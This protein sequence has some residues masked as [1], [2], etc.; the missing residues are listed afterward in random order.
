MMG[1]N[2][3]ITDI[4]KG[5]YPVGKG[6]ITFKVTETEFIKPLSLLKFSPPEKC[7]I[8]YYN[9]EKKV[10]ASSKEFSKSIKKTLNNYFKETKNV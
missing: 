1:V 9:K 8:T 10:P 6:Y 3:E 2:M 4:K 5:Y 7:V